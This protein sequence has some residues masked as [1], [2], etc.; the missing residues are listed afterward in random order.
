LLYRLHLDQTEQTERSKQASVSSDIRKR[1]LKKFD[2]NFPIHVVDALDKIS[3]EQYIS[4]DKAEELLE[5]LVIA[6]QRSDIYDKDVLKKVFSQRI[7]WML[8]YNTIKGTGLFFAFRRSTFRHMLPLTFYT[9]FKF[10][11]KC[12]IRYSHES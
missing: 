9:E 10:F 11:I 4:L 2:Y 3:E 5:H 6:N 1:I 8:N 7:W 12:L